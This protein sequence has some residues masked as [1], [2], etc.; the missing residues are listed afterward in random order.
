MHEEY[1]KEHPIIERTQQEK[2]TELI[3][4]ILK[5]REELEEANKNFE[6]AEGDLIDY[7]T[8]QIK[9]S[10]AK[11]DYLIKK[12]KKQGIVLDMIDQIEMRFREAM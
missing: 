12:A 4:S 5:T 2:Q 8:Y 11:I 10:R 6:Y 1:I 3:M 9:A 7:Y